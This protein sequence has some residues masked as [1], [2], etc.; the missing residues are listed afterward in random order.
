VGVGAGSAGSAGGTGRSPSPAKR[1]AQGSG[2]RAGSVT[3]SPATKSRHVS[4]TAAAAAADADDLP[5]AQPLPSSASSDSAAAAASAAP[6]APLPA[7]LTQ[8]PSA[9]LMEDLFAA[10]VEQHLHCQGG[11][12]ATTRAASSFHFKMLY[13]AQRVR[14]CRACFRDAVVRGPHVS[15]LHACVCPCA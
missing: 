8:L 3:S 1:G 5:D 9:T 6:A 7:V 13:P 11:K 10:K 2:S 15:F 4:A 12:H 14:E